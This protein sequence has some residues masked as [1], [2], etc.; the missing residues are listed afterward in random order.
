MPLSLLLSYIASAV[1]LL[2]FLLFEPLG[3]EAVIFPVLKRG[4]PTVPNNYRPI[5]L[6]PVISKVF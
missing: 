4:D 1:F 3:K 5:A 6:T 2:Y